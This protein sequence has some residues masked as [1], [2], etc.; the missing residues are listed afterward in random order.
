MVP[1]GTLL[2]SQRSIISMTWARSIQDINDFLNI[3]FNIIFLTV[4]WSSNW[5][6]S[7]RFPTKTLYSPLSVSSILASW[8]AHLML[9]DLMKNTNHEAT[10]CAVLPSPLLLC[11][12]LAQV[13]SSASYSQTP[14][15]CVLP[16]AWQIILKAKGKIT[17]LYILIIIF[18]ETKWVDGWSGSGHSQSVIC[19]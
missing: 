5:F 16:P 7:L 9:L 17:V 13:S 10:N 3:N 19:L 1:K 12:S 11:S 14:S 15:N 2:N 8:P 18:L 4:P 6:L